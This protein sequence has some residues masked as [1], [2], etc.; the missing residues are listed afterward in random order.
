MSGLFSKREYAKIVNK[1]LVH[2]R[3]CKPIRVAMIKSE[4]PK[5]LRMKRVRFI[6]SLNRIRHLFVRL[7]YLSK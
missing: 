4:D 3:R 1:T 7:M 2:R 5:T 6:Y